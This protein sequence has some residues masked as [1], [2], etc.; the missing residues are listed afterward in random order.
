MKKIENVEKIEDLILFCNK[1]IVN[2]F[3]Y[4]NEVIQNKFQESLFKLL[5]TYINAHYNDNKYQYETE[6]FV[7]AYVL[8]FCSE[9][10]YKEE[11]IDKNTY[12]SFLEKLDIIKKF[13]IRE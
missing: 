6:L 11:T 12:K 10:L 9:V 13:A 7:I 3:T 1:N 4:Q 2:R 5:E 8:T